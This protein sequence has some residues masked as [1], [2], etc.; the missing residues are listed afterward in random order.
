MVIVISPILPSPIVYIFN[1]IFAEFA[2][3][4]LSSGWKMLVCAFVYLTDFTHV[5][6]IHMCRIWHVSVMGVCVCVMVS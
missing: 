3:N 1:E 5:L 2:Q 6:L 4:S